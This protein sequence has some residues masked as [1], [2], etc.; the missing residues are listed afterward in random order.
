MI[1]V[2]QMIQRARAATGLE[3]FGDLF[4]RDGFEALVDSVNR[5]SD[6]T[7]QAAADYQDRM[8]RVLVNL[9]RMQYDLDRHPEIL[10]QQLIDPVFISCLP[11]T[12]STKLHRMLCETG[13]FQALLFWQ[14]HNP[15]RI[16]GQPDGG[17]AERRA[18]ARQYLEWLER[19]AP[20]FKIAHPMYL[21]QTEEELILFEFSFCSAHPTSLSRVPDYLDWLMRQ[22]VSRL[23]GFLRQVLQYLQWQFHREETRPW[24]LKCPLNLGMEQTILGEFPNAKFI[25]TH[26]D[27]V[28]LV[29]SVCRLLEASREMYPSRSLGSE[30]EMLSG[31]RLFCQAM[32]G[33]LAWRAAHPDAPIL[34]LG[35]EQIN[36]NGLGS[37]EETLK[38][39]G[40]DFTE[41]DRRSVEQWMADNRREKHGRHRYSL[42]D[43]GLT[44][45]GVNE[46]FAG[47]I[48][49]FADYL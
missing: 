25:A 30:E 32:D 27:P 5:Q 29:P 28:K 4:F 18:D 42:E 1:L 33:Q 21:D 36:E 31:S 47:Y 49:R 46:Q 44:E 14:G 12:G 7:E 20:D 35:F 41:E 16:P 34:D 48:G 3:N 11:R 8:H 39:L 2:E 24:L 23:Y 10:Q 15:A 45:Q 26:R 9:L 22:D 43:F 13:K 19:N 40:M 38:F 17:A 6:L 37:V